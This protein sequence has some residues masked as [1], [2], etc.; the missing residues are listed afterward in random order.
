LG[1]RVIERTIPMVNSAKIYAEML[2]MDIDIK[3]ED[4]P[5]PSSIQTLIILCHT[6]EQKTEKFLLEVTQ[7]LTTMSNRLRLEQLNYDIKKR[8]ILTSNEAVKR[9]PS[10]KDRE[11]RTDEILENDNRT[12]V[13]LQNQVNTLDS[14][15]KAIKAVQSRLKNSAMAVRQIQKVA[16]IQ[17]GRLN[18]GRPDDPEV[19]DL[20]DGLNEIDKQEEIDQESVESATETVESDPGATEALESSDEDVLAEAVATAITDSDS[21]S[22]QTA[23]PGVEGRE[24]GQE[25]EDADISAF[26]DDDTEDSAAAVDPGEDDVG[27]D[28]SAEVTTPAEDIAV[29]AENVPATDELDIDLSSLDIAI[30]DAGGVE[31]PPPAEPVAATVDRT[32]PDKPAPA[33]PAPTPADV[34]STVQEL[35]LD[36]DALINDLDG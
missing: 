15:H 9:L 12:L 27:G 16:E 33:A 32:E 31:T 36:I 34:K 4:V 19:R 14:L 28:G 35:D 5:T 1:D 11:A 6:H 20:M 2:K 30:D 25:S 3:Y 13:D 7:E 23:T 26:M 22:Q 21:G 29:P 10:I 17:V 8:T 18:I 24:E